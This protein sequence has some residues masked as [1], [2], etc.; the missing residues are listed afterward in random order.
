MSDTDT[1]PVV[2][3]PPATTPGVGNDGNWEARFKGLQALLSQKEAAWTLEKQSLQG[4]VT[5]LTQEAHGYHEQ[6]NTVQGTVKATQEQLH[7]VTTE[8]DSNKELAATAQ[9]GNDRLKTIMKY[10]S[11]APFEDRGALRTDL[12]GAEFETHLKTVLELNGMTGPA[13]IA[14]AI[15]PGK[16]NARQATPDALALISQM[17]LLYAD[18]DKQDELHNLQKQYA[19]A[20]RGKQ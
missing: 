1:Q 19:D 7:A 12:T 3:Q 13:P 5:Q 16:G 9:R 6:L 2:T 14:G 4:T 10:P 8:R 15:P 11:L 18:P 17:R 20:V